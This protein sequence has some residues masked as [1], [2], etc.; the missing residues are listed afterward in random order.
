[1]FQLKRARA[2]CRWVG[3]VDTLGSLGGARGA[4]AGGCPP[5]RP[6]C[7]PSRLTAD[8]PTRRRD[9]RGAQARQY[10]VTALD[11]SD[12]ACFDNSPGSISLGS[13]GRGGA[14]KDGVA[15]TQ[16]GPTSMCCCMCSCARRRCPRG[17]RGRTR[18]RSVS[19]PRS[20]RASGDAAHLTVACE[21]CCAPRNK[22]CLA[23]APCAAVLR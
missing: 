8:G 16:V 17:S 21:P 22:V 10:F 4:R 12:T 23:F 19:S 14:D 9:A 6:M 18:P 13:P 15:W 7:P 11:P 20:R 1:M 2:S 5:R 3:G